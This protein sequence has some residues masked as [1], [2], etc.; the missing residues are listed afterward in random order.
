LLFFYDIFFVLGTPVMVAVATNVDAPIK[1]LFPKA[2]AVSDAD[3]QFSMLGLGDIVI[4]GIFIALLLRFDAQRAGLKLQD[5][6]VG[7]RMLFSR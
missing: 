7:Q 4:P 6:Q 1:L 2:F 5:A 3:A